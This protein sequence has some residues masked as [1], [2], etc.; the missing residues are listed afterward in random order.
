[1]AYQT[2]SATGIDDLLDKL[3]LFLTS[4]GWTQNLF[5]PDGD[6]YR[7]HL[8][9]GA[10][11]VNFRSTQTDPPSGT[12]GLDA[13]I[14]VNGSEGFDGGAAWDAQPNASPSSLLR[15]MPGA[16]PNYWF[17]ANGDCCYVVVEKSVGAFM[18]MAFGL[19]EKN[20]MDVAQSGAF[21]QACYIPPSA[22]PDVTN[23]AVLFDAGQSS[24]NYPNHIRVDVDGV[25]GTWV[26][27]SSSASLTPR[28]LGP[29]RKK[30]LNEDLIRAQPNTFCQRTVLLPMPV[31]VNRPSN[32]YSIIGYPPDIA[33][34]V[35]NLHTPADELT[36]GADTWVIFP[37]ATRG[38]T[39]GGMNAYAYRKVV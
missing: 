25:N 3:R 10:Q 27:F 22:T 32:L 6:G 1:M 30:G 20:G 5:Q 11:F 13:H 34:C 17:F 39:F 35:I 8:Y 38:D 12:D 19:L 33:Q 36:L 15:D 23:A 16:L 18:H 4:N 7:L 29:C 28:A 21:I 9:K 31:L 14:W 24:S 2:G 26:E 37:W